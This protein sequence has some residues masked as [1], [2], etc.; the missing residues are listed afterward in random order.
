MRV[1]IKD[2]ARETGLSPTAVSLVL[3]HRPNK[4]SAESRE[5]I[6]ETAKRLH[7]VPNQLAVGLVTR[8]THTLG[9]IIPN[10]ANQYYATLALGIDEEARKHG[11]N[12]LFIN[13]N[14]RAQNDLD[15]LRLLSS[16]GVDALI[17]AV[18]SDVDAQTRG[19]Y[20][21]FIQKSSVPVV[22]VNHEEPSFR[23]STVKLNNRAGAYEAVTHLLELGH[24]D[25]AYIT[26]DEDLQHTHTERIQGAMQACADMGVP[27]CKKY[28]RSGRYT[29]EGG[30]Q[31]AQE[32][33]SLPISAL[34]CFNDMMAFGAFQKI[35]QM[36]LK[37]PEDISLVGF[38][39]VPFAALLDVPLT[40][41]KQPAYEIGR[42]TVRV[43]L[44]EIEDRLRSKQQI[45]FEPELVLRESTAP[46]VPKP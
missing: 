10:I 31:A 20:R 35:R 7:Y 45:Q 23:C 14:D 21:S 12:I 6:V 41:V 13:T 38:D 25:I 36:G 27:F 3:N 28:V 8:Q 30:A 29:T 16:R 17:L 44:G 18:A 46:F 26:G 40:T 33:L 9:L 42:E 43:A 1:T 15:S 37:V 39:D 32:L 11:W 4:L 19:E 24:R 5:L 34:F 22:L 2:I